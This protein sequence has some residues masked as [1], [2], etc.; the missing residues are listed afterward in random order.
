MVR[1]SEE[2]ETPLKDPVMNYFRLV[3][4][5]TV[6]A[7][8]RRCLFLADKENKITKANNFTRHKEL[9][10]A[11]CEIQTCLAGFLVSSI[12]IVLEHHQSLNSILVLERLSK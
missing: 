12:S 8:Q 6:S 1:C 9:T 5:N 11:R 7:F 3:N 2:Q 4:S 10:I